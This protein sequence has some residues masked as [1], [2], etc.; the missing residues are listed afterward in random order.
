VLRLYELVQDETADSGSRHAAAETLVKHGLLRRRR[1]G[2]SI[3]FLWLLGATF[4]IVCAAAADSIGA[5]AI[6][7]FVAGI[8]ALVAYRRRAAR[9][10]RE[11]AT[12][13]GP[14]GAT[15]QLP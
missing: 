5:G 1:I 13:I 14:D 6:A 9:L 8:G 15:I 7:L 10:E 3:V 2:P 11:S 12:Y 4:A